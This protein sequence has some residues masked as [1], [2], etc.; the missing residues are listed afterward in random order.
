MNCLFMPVHAK[1]TALSMCTNCVDKQ[2]V[3]KADPILWI[4]RGADPEIQPQNSIAHL[5]QD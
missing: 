3:A 5:S 2:C 1:H 4:A